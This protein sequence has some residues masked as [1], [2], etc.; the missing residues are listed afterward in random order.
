MLAAY[1]SFDD[2]NDA[3]GGVITFVGLGFYAG[4]IYG[5]T[6]SA[7]KYNRNKERGFIEN[8]KREEID[9]STRISDKGVALCFNY[10]F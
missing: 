5:A 4:N 1:E 6:T 8:L 10:F 7:H 3:L 9:F 2:G